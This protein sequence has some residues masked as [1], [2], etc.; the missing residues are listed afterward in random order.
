[1]SGG[2][3]VTF[4][5]DE[6][7]CLA[8]GTHKG[9]DGASI[10]K[11]PEADF[12]SCGINSDVG[13]AIY[14]DTDGSNGTVTA[15]TEDT[16]TCTLTGG[17]NNTWANGDTYFIYK[18]D[19]KGATLSTHYTDKRFGRK[20]TDKAELVDGIQPADADLDEHDEHVFGPGQPER[21]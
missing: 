16:V 10:L 5:D 20:V 18:T 6:D 13:Q 21:R 14:N 7:N 3:P 8:T 15:S 4:T 17:T 11:D 12:L 9:A 1:M 2:I 19:T